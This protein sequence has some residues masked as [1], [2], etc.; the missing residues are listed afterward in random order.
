MWHAAAASDIAPFVGGVTVTKSPTEMCET[1]P[2]FKISTPCFPFQMHAVAPVSSNG[3][4]LLGESDKFVPVSNQRIASVT[5]AVSG[6]FTV[7]LKG[8]ASE[9]VTMGA[10]DTKGSKA[11]VY[12]TATIGQ[13]GTAALVLK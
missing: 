7:Q 5:A 8:A 12:A 10:V 1:S 9:T 11:P 2:S 6:G 4:A 3:W 13:D